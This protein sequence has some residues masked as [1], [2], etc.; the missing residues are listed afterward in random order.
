MMAEH[1]DPTKLTS[2]IV[3]ATISLALVG[4]AY[5]LTPDF[6]EQRL[7]PD[8]Q[9]S[10]ITRGQISLLRLSLCGLAVLWP[11]L[12]ACRGSIVRDFA[13]LPMRRRLLREP[14][15]LAVPD[16]LG[17]PQ[18]ARL[19]TLLWILLPIWFLVVH[20]TFLLKISWP[21]IIM[22]ELG[23]Q[24]NLTVLL[25]LLAGFL[26]LRQV[27][28]C[29]GQSI[30]PGLYKWWSL[31]L[32]SFCVLVALEE[33]NYG[34]VYF[35]F[36]TP[37]LM[38]HVN[39]QGDFSLHN[40]R[41]PDSAPGT[42][43]YW[44]NHVCWGIALLLAAAPSLLWVSP[45]L[46]QFV[47]VLAIPV[48]PLLAQGYFAA[49]TLTWGDNWMFSHMMRPTEMREVSMAIAFAVWL[50]TESLRY[51]PAIGLAGSQATAT[52]WGQPLTLPQLSGV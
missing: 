28:R 46:R 37:D 3:V 41:L 49:A 34:Q 44:A 11:I 50:W 21:S 23:I 38:A 25:Y 14:Q 13:L 5:T 7:A 42:Q 24:E 2:R 12:W 22:G 35:Q 43:M 15:R 40:L 30:L 16:L 27:W 6:V 9:I 29:R 8:G 1:R 18:P 4:L 31:A 33:M 17:R 51:R 52:N 39:Y 20:L 47:W 19:A 45:R 32:G 26:A 36:A 10:D 48:P